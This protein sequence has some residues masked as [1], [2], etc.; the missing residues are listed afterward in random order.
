MSRTF[1]VVTV[2]GTSSESIDDA[3][4][5]AI[6]DAS[7]T[8]RNLGWFEVQEVRGRIA[9]EGVLEYQVKLEIGFKVEGG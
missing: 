1:K 7:D 9:G 3:I 2:A 5:G 8:L 4:Q 6:V